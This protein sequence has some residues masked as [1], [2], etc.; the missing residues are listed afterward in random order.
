MTFKRSVLCVAAVAAASIALAGGASA[1][2]ITSAGGG[3]TVGIGGNG[4]LYDGASGVGFRRNGDGFDPIA[5]G[6]P[7][8]SWG[9]GVVGGA[10]AY[11]D[12]QFYGSTVAGTAFTFGA[13]SAQAITDTGLGLTVT[14]N[15]SFVDGGNILRI[16]TAVRND[17]ADAIDAVFQRV[18]DWDI[19]LDLGENVTG[20][21]GAAPVLDSTDY[22][23]ESPNPNDG[24]FASSCLG[25]CNAKG[26]LGG[27][28]RIALGSLAGGAT[29]HFVYFYGLNYA[30]ESLDDLV[31]EGHAAGASYIIGGQS[32][33]NGVYPN[34]GANS[35]FIGVGGVPE[36][37]T[38]AMM[39]LGFFGLGAAVRRRRVLAA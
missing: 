13:S 4:E 35:A 11:A 15:Y 21:F 34:L 27:G 16:D 5:P 30:G 22:G 29:S 33:E 9:I 2:T 1:Q 28:I 37:A 36:P 26:D 14:Q 10:G 3:F 24:P 12:G 31:A 18:V 17:G 6:T 25:G 7:R 39:I 8:D 19:D 32:P 20:P 23:F 38:W